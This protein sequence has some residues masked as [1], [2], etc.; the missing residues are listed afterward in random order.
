MLYSY[1]IVFVAQIIR[2]F[3]IWL[4]MKIRFNYLTQETTFVFLSVF[5]MSFFQYA[6]VPLV[7]PVDDRDLPKIPF[8]SQFL[9]R[10]GIFPD[11]N[12]T[13]FNRVGGIICY[14]M[15]FNAFWPLI[16]FSYTWA[17]RWLFR[18]ID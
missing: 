14:N 12:S 10:N 3:L 7:S 9:F 13:W 4:A 1:V 16:E 15:T 18:A 5:Y 6:V 11:F 2:G 8:L 17:L